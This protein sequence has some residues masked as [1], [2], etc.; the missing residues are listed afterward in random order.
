VIIYL[1]GFASGPGSQKARMFR[2]RFGP[3]LIVPD[4]AEGNF[5]RLTVTGQLRLVERIAAGAPV[6][7]IGSSLGGY[8]AALYAARHPETERLVLL[9]PAFGFANRFDS[10]EWR[11]DGWLT[12]HHYASGAPARVHYG[13]IEDARGYEEFPGFSQPALILHGSN[14][15]S[16]PLE[17][18]ER[19]AAR[20]PNVRLV[21]LDSDHQLLDKSEQVWEETRRFLDGGL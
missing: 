3:G 20:R 6:R 5:E 21:V 11:R 9:A 4:L 7:L 15:T 18:S 12:V 17:L 13:L 10:T 8:L 14:D 2:E 16:V 19:F 1:H